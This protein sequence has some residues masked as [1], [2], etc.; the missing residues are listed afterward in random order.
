MHERLMDLEGRVQD[1]EANLQDIQLDHDVRQETSH[2]G[3]QVLRLAM[4]MQRLEHGGVDGT[5]AEDLEEV[6]ELRSELGDF[7][8]QLLNLTGRLSHAERGLSGIAEA[9]SRVC[10][11]LAQLRSARRPARSS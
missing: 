6:R 10:E 3:E 7:S 5:S 11:E 9:F 8:E 4:R 2:I 1:T